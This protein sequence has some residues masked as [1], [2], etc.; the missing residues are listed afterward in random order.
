M[1]SRPM[2]SISGFRDERVNVL[3]VGVNSINLNDAVATIERWISERSRNY[4][5][6]TGVHGVMESRRNEQLR[7]IH[8][9]AGMVTPDGMPL[10]WLSHRF[11]KHRKDRVYGPDLMRRRKAG[12]ARRGC[13]EG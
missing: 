6:V 8:N 12:S 1:E 11:G 9:E 10:V 13:G 5:C 4:V 7:R 3:G 2:S